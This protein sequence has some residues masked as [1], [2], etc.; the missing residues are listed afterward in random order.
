[1]PRHG[2]VLTLALLAAGCFLACSTQQ[3]IHTETALAQALISDE[4]SAQLGEQVH[5]ELE[6]KGVRYVGNREVVSYVEGVAGRIFEQARR[7]RPGIPYH[8]HVIDDP[9]TVNA[10]AAPGGHLYVYSG[11]ILA[12]ANEA[13]LAGVL[14]HETGHVALRHVERAMVNSF[15]FQ[16]LAAAALGDNPSTVKEIAAGV[17]GTGVLRAH[18]RSE[19]TE[20]DEY[21]ARVIA[22]LDYDPNAM[23]TFF[24]TLQS[25]E[26]KSP[27]ALDW[28]RTH[29]VTGDRIRHLRAFIQQNDL[30]GTVLAA[31]RHAEVQAQLTARAQR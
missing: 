21:G 2:I 19:E 30:H 20:A 13:E 9:K 1:M 25:G 5:R 3:R 29:P 26:A 7:D 12:T 4:Q 8:V 28:L 18:S 11:L 16:A 23:L 24:Q 14:G 6:A 27:A 17:L 22:G 10:F 15:G 31:R